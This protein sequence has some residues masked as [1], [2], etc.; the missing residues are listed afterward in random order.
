MKNDTQNITES[1]LQQ[2]CFIWKHNTDPLRRGRL[3]HVN[4]TPRNEISG[5]L[6]IG[7]GL[8]KGIS[9][10]IYICPVNCPILFIE[11]K[12]SGKHQTPQQK[13]FQQLVIS[14]GHNYVICRNL[15]EFQM[16]INNADNNAPPANWLP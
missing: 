1:K 12:L 4:N 5:S 13:S 11:I 14:L 3:F 8:V 2:Q 15:L 16:Q 7:M 6:L 9:D 10:L